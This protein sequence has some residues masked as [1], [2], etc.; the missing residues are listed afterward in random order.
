MRNKAKMPKLGPA[1]TIDGVMRRYDYSSCSWVETKRQENAG[2]N[3]Q[4]L[5]KLK[6]TIDSLPG[7]DIKM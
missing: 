7:T 3:T 5:K 6:S 2:N 4:N 1:I